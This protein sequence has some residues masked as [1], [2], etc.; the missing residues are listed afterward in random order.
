[1]ADERDI[2]DRLRKVPLFSSLPEE[3]LQELARLVKRRSFSA[4]GL[5]LRQGEPASALFVINSGLVELHHTD[6]RGGRHGIASLAVGDSFGESSFL[7]GEPFHATA[8]AVSPVELLVLEK[9]DFDRL[10]ERNHQLERLL[11][12]SRRAK[13]GIRK[14]RFPGQERG[15]VVLSLQRQHWYG[16]MTALAGPLGILIWG[17]LFLAILSSN[18][19]IILPAGIPPLSLA[20]AWAIWGLLRWRN[21][22]FILTDRRIIHLV[23]VLFVYQR[24]W[25]APL[26][27]IESATVAHSLGSGDLT[28]EMEGGVAGRTFRALPEAELARQLIFAQMSRSTEGPRHPISS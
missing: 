10:R 28:I 3:A 13:S 27:R 25:E 9:Q 19:P 16:L 24:R 17:G 1:M 14:R 23:R 4:G 15:E 22:Y 21:D 2:L 26:E 5:I 18:W 20:A 11:R 12:L 6:H 7:A 8:I